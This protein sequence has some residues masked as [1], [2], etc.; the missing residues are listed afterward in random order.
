MV[1]VINDSL[2]EERIIAERRATGADRYD[3]VWA[4]V[5]MMSPIANTEHQGLVTKLTVILATVV[6][7]EGLG[8]SFPGVHVSDRRKTWEHNYRCPDV[9]V[10]LSGT[11]AIDCNTHWL[12]G[13]DFG[14]EIV[15]PG[16]RSREKLDFYAKVKTREL[17]IVDREPWALE[18]YR[19]AKDQLSLVDSA[20][21]E[22]G[23]TLA[24]E[25]V[26]LSLRLVAGTERPQI[27]VTQRDGERRWTV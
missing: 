26:P 2:L 5:Y 27:E 13:P 19:L 3:E 16:D 17:L 8:R 1:A 11:A 24:S 22:N 14:V 4:G 12:G 9:A 20:T 21:V 18:L 6:D 15:S 25:V 10:F 7:F 23:R